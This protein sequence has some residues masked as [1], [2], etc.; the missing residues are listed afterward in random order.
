M[1]VLY[2]KVD[3]SVGISIFQ[4]RTKKYFLSVFIGTCIFCGA[5]F[6]N[7]LGKVYGDEIIF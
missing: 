1:I 6:E 7:F 4:D 3:V 2:I 5:I